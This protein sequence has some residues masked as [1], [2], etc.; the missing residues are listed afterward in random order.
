MPDRPVM[1][2]IE[3]VRKTLG[4]TQQTIASSRMSFIGQR[5]QN[6]QGLL[7]KIGVKSAGGG[8]FG[9]GYLPS[10]GGSGA[11]SGRESSKQEFGGPQT[12]KT[13]ETIY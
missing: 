7:S 12:L 10:A 9:F 2:A 6:T 5:S 13:A 8:L 4:M 1:N 11:P 3:N